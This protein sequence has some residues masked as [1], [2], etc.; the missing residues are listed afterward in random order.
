AMNLKKL[1][2][3]SWKCSFLPPG[4]H[5]FSRFRHLASVLALLNSSFFDKL[6]GPGQNVQGLLIR[7][8]SA[9]EEGFKL[10]K[11]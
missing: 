6:S 5:C 2:I 3:W 7:N 11:S 1:A 8:L 4:S 10:Q 9:H